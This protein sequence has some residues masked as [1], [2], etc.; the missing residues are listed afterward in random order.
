MDERLG[1]HGR[2]RLYGVP[3]SVLSTH[4]PI[5]RL[6][7]YTKSMN[8]T[9]PNFD[10]FSFA[11]LAGRVGQQPANFANDMEGGDFDDYFTAEDYDR[12][13]YETEMRRQRRGY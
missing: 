8:N 7:P 6:T 11:A 3:M 13:R 12:R 1:R 2:H 10:R 9:Q 4:S 5:A